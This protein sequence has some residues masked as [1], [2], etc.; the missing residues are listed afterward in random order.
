MKQQENQMLDQ[1]ILLSE[2][3]RDNISSRKRKR[4]V[5]LSTS[6][7]VSIYEADEFFDSILIHPVA[8][9][10]RSNNNNYSSSSN[11]NDNNSNNNNSNCNRLPTSIQNDSNN[12]TSRFSSSCSTLLVRIIQQLDRSNC[13]KHQNRPETKFSDNN[14]NKPKNDNFESKSNLPQERDELICV[15]SENR[16]LIRQA[17][18]KLLYLEKDSLKFHKTHC[19]VYFQQLKSRMDNEFAAGILSNILTDLDFSSNSNLNNSNNN[20]H[21][22]LSSNC[23]KLYYFLNTEIKILEDNLYRRVVGGSF[24]P[25]IFRQSDLIMNL[26]DLSNDGFEILAPLETAAEDEDDNFDY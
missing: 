5:D 17:I 6:C 13:F 22:Q 12:T 3:E 19:V 7:T 24:I 18:V 2:G 4:K 21:Q 11:N 10:C 8:A 14:N 16:K 9:E 15:C 25:Y 20:N 1:A 23:Q 26:Y